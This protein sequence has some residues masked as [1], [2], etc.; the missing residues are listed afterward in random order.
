MPNKAERCPPVPLSRRI[1]DRLSSV[2]APPLES[3]EIPGSRST[4]P[5][6]SPMRFCPRMFARAVGWYGRGVP[7]SL[8]GRDSE[9]AP[10]PVFQRPCKI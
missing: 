9:G 8:G 7:I 3:G 10:C 6:D 5:E 2:S 1:R 4:H